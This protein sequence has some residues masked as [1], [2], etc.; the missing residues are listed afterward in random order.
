MTDEPKMEDSGERRE[1]KSGAVRDRGGFKPRPDLISPHANLRE[2]AWLAKGA[3]KYGVRNYEK[4]IPISE[5][6]ASLNRH[7]EA[8]KLGSQE[9]D[10]MA[11]IRT[12]AGFILHYEEEIKA[13]RMDPAIDDMPKYA[14][15]L[16]IV[17][18]TGTFT[19]DEDAS[20][21]AVWMSDKKLTVMGGPDLKP[22]FDSRVKT[23]LE[24]VLPLNALVPSAHP[25]GPTAEEYLAYIKRAL[26]LPERISV[27]ECITLAT[28]LLK[29]DGW[30]DPHKSTPPTLTFYITGPMR[31]IPDLN[32]PAFDAVAKVARDRGWNVISPAESDREHGITPE[33]KNV[34]IAAVAKRDCEAIL[35]L[36]KDRGDGLILLPGW[37]KSV[38]A[39]AEIALALW[40]GLS[41]EIPYSDSANIKGFFSTSPEIVRPQLFEQSRNNTNG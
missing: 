33:T 14:S 31:G 3:E 32:F 4:G 25:T 15:R 36:D 13:G 20:I 19:S 30:S 10:H 23:L 18:Y 8:Y 5:C 9:E 29:E 7:L 26:A 16:S 41:F 40:L 38:G 34:D 28:D 35:N 37:E 24:D 39:R 22:S 2:G 12:N 21:A 6:L 11:A 1:F 27:G 17:P